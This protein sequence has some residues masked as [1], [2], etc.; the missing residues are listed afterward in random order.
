[1]QNMP[2]QRVNTVLWIAIWK[3]TYFICECIILT[4]VDENATTSAANAI[5]NKEQEKIVEEK[6][7]VILE[8]AAKIQE[9][10]TKIE[11]VSKRIAEL[12]TEVV[13]SNEGKQK[14]EHELSE[15]AKKCSD[16]Q[17]KCAGFFNQVVSLNS[18]QQESEEEISSLK[19]SCENFRAQLAE[20]DAM[21]MMMRDSVSLF[22]ILHIT[23]QQRQK[24]NLL[25]YTIFSSAL[26]H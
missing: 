6:E 23:A 2:L 21:M 8:Q 12:S 22:Y 3:L 9:L 18:K 11:D 10:L 14:V 13:K 1:M 15:T 20:K 25:I 7:K 4:Q 17:K 16:F 19:R 24:F 26:Q 5:S